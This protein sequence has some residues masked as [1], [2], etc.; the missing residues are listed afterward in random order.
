VAR[1]AGASIIGKDFYCDSYGSYAKTTQKTK[2]SRSLRGQEEEFHCNLVRDAKT[3]LSTISNRL[4]IGGAHG[5]GI[6]RR[7]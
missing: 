1:S 4:A 2:A 3:G 7:R 5:A 6:R